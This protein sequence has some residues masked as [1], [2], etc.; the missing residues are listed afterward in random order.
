MSKISFQIKD[1]VS[2]IE[3]KEPSPEWKDQILRI[4]GIKDGAASLYNRHGCWGVFSLT[5][6][7][8]VDRP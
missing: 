8:A 3:G 1:R 7:K 2:F 6:L 5:S 4:G